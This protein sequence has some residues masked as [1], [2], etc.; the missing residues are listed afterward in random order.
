MDVLSTRPS[1]RMPVR[2]ARMKSASDHA[3]RP[4][5]VMLAART[6]LGGAF[7]ILPPENPGAWQLE[8]PAVS[9]RYLPYS[10]VTPATGAGGRA[11]KWSSPAE[12]CSDNWPTVNSSRPI[13]RISLLGSAVSMAGSDLT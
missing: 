6:A 11:A 10:R 8:Q 7:G 13:G 1:G 3:P 12:G 9:A 2:I 5:A 4:A